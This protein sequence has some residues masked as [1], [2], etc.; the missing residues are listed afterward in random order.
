M[1]YGW[2]GDQLWKW[3][4]RDSHLGDAHVSVR[5]RIT[6]VATGSLVILHLVLHHLSLAL[7]HASELHRCNGEPILVISEQLTWYNEIVLN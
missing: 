2:F 4:E 7:R 6:A 3:E 1:I 5:S